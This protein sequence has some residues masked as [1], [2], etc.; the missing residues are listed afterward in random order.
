MKKRRLL[1]AS[2]LAFF[3]LLTAL[4]VRAQQ[5]VSGTLRSATGEPLAGATVTVKGT[6]TSVSTN[7][8][9]EFTINAPAGSTLVV[10]YVGYATQEVAATSSG[11]LNIQLQA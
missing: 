9:G 8:S 2:F 5:P 4:G 7:A 10:S 6:T 3:V 11:P 1:Y